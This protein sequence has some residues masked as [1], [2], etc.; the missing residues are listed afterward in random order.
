[1]EESGVIQ[2]AGAHIEALKLGLRQNLSEEGEDF[3]AEEV[4]VADEGGDLGLG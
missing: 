3:V 1:M 2:A 4:L